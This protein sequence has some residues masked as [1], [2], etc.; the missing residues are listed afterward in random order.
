VN[1]G[2]EKSKRDEAKTRAEEAFQAKQQRDDNVKAQLRKERAATE[3][4]TKKLRGL[5]L[6]HEAKGQAV[7]R[8]IGEGI[9]GMPLPARKAKPKAK[10][11][12]K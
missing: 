4:K 10:T 11:R 3:A 2:D 8:S 6:E 9:S 12:K 1:P 7:A 5:R